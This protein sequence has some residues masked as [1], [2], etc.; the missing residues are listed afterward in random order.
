MQL[1]ISL[2][3]TAYLLCFQACNHKTTKQAGGN[4]QSQTVKPEETG[5]TLKVAKV[6]VDRRGQIFL[7]ETLVSLDEL[8]K[9]FSDLK[10]ANGTVW[11]Y[12]ENPEGEPTPEAMSVIQAVIDAQLPIR[13]SSKPDYSDVVRP[14][15]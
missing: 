12:R 7:N 2:L 5:N 1:L 8:K 9:A 14:E 3:A 13:L 6:R 10:Q 4:Q 11:Y 15:R